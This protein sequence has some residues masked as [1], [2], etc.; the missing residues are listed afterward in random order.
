[1]KIEVR[2]KAK[3]LDIQI[4]DVV[5]VKRAYYQVRA[6]E[7]NPFSFGLY[8]LNGCEVKQ[9]LSTKAE[10]LYYLELNDGIVY[11]KEN[12]KLVITEV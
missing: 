2:E 8:N 9:N 1:M 3:E 6:K 10:I 7:D 5:F 12:Y 4:G 11:S